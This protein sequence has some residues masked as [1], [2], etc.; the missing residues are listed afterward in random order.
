MTL[1]TAEKDIIKAKVVSDLEK[2]IYTLSL[3][4]VIDPEEALT[5]NSFEEL[6]D[7]S[8]IIPPLGEPTE[9]TFQSLFNQIQ[10]LKSLI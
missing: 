10:A 9:L 3:M 5:V 1:S 4:C 2:S 7:I 6:V 8:S